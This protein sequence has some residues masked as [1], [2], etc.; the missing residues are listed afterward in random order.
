MA[1]A[2]YDLETY[3]GSDGEL[4]HYFGVTCGRCGKDGFHWGYHKG[5]S[6]LFDG[7]GDLHVCNQPKNVIPKGGETCKRC[8]QNGFRWMQ[9]QGQWRLHTMDGKLHVCEGLAYPGGE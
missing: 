5:R 3:G 1:G 7:H 9:H 2:E 6:R 8:G 4:E